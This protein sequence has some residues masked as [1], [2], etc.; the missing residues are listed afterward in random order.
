MS[1]AT[2]PAALETFAADFERLESNPTSNGKTQGWLS[3]LRR[4]A[5]SRFLEAGFP[6]T[7]L[8]DWKFTDVSPIARTAFR[9][10]QGASEPALAAEVLL[11]LLFGDGPSARLVFVNGRYSAEWSAKLSG[12]AAPPAGVFAGSLAD[13]LATRGPEI[14]PRLA[15]H[16]LWEDQPFAALNT[17]FLADGA[18][19]HIDRGAVLERPLHLVFVSTAADEPTASH[20][21]NLILA[22]A[23]SQ[24][25]IVETYVGWSPEVYLTNSVT[26]IVLE[27][28]AVLDHSRVQLE[29]EKA[30]HVATVAAHQSRSSNWISRSVSLGAGLARIDIGTVLDA[31]GAECRLD[32]LYLARGRQHVDHHTAID[33]ARP[34]CTSREFYKGI[35]DGRSKAVF[36]GKI[37]VRP[38]AQKTDARQANRNLILSDDTSVNSK[39][40]L[41]IF[42]NDVKCAH[43]ATVGQIERDALFYL[44]SRGIPADAARALLTYAFATEILDEVGFEPLRAHLAR[45]VAARLPAGEA[46]TELT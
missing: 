27:D 21:R 2:D 18:F 32:G 14:E 40:E 12:G 5:M 31:E 39:P 8:E 35:L 23:N 43:G 15:R 6:T 45:L 37:V 36:N 11:P 24:S 44:R 25:R 19:V 20:P 22:G 38:D 29:S 26:E 7:R 10:P 9:L 30:F 42:A 1:I 28:G 41:Q 34:Y 16:A 13:A 4:R 17:A 33:H 3:D 46:L